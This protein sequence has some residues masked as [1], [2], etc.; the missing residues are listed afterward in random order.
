MFISVRAQSVTLSVIEAN[1]R[2]LAG[3][4]LRGAPPKQGN[5]MS[6]TRSDNSL[7]LVVVKRRSRFGLLVTFCDTLL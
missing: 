1:Y 4:L 6:K 2:Q 5:V 3:W 7:E